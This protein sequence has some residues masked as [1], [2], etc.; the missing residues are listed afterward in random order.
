MHIKLLL[1]ACLSSYALLY[2]TKSW[3]N[4]AFLNLYPCHNY[5]AAVVLSLVPILEVSLSCGEK[6]VWFCELLKAI[7]RQESLA[8]GCVDCLVK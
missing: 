1:F 3:R 5:I 7:D 4:A 6:R 8:G 2:T